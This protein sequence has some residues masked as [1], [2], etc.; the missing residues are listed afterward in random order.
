M[1]N[2]IDFTSLDTKDLTRDW[3]IEGWLAKGD[4]AVLAGE[5]YCGKSFL[6]MYL[7]MG[8]VQ[9]ESWITKMQVPK[10]RR[11]LYIDE[12]NNRSSIELRLQTI[13]R[14]RS[15]KPSEWAGLMPY[16]YSNG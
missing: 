15:R 5:P 11:I 12:D 7:A 4:L 3:I 1:I 14:R 16:L 8:I 13:P 10:S 6:A 9:G 2:T